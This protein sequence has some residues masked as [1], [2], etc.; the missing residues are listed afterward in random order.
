MTSPYYVHGVQVV[1]CGGERCEACEQRPAVGAS[2]SGSLVC[3]RCAGWAAVEAE[4]L[5]REM[6]ASRERRA[7]RDSVALERVRQ[8]VALLEGQGQRTSSTPAVSATAKKQRQS[9]AQRTDNRRR[10]AADS[11]IRRAAQARGIRH[12]ALLAVMD[13][14]RKPLS[15]AQ[16]ANFSRLSLSTVKRTV[17]EL[18][19]EGRVTGKRAHKTSTLYYAVKVAS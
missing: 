12:A 5:A 18:V 11:N 15:S 13:K 2:L 19:R 8:K 10:A 1:N 9:L 7:G 16:L 6:E 17:T 3:A 14:V 4:E